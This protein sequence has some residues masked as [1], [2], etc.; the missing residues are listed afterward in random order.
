MMGG[1]RGERGVISPCI[2][3]CVLDPAGG[4]CTGCGRTLAEIAAWP[5]MSE[6]ERAA[7]MARL[8]RGADAGAAGEEAGR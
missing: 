2:R 1:G 7:V 5:T 8:A 3:V 6:R 4:V